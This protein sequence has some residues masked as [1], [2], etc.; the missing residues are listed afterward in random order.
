MPRGLLEKEHM[1]S[2][3]RSLIFVFASAGL[4][5]V[6]LAGPNSIPDYSKESKEVAP[7]PP[8]P[9]CDWTG[10]YIGL[11][12]GGQFGDSHDVDINGYNLRGEHWGYDESGFVGGGQAGYNW[13]WKWLVLGPEFD[14]GY[15]N[16]DGSH[17][18][19][20]SIPQS[21]GDTSGKSDSDLYVT[22][23]GRV[24]VNVDWHGC[25][26]LYATGGGIGVNYETRVVDT[27]IIP[28]AGDGLIDAHKEEFVW[29][30]TVG[31]GIERQ[32]GRHWSVKIEYLYFNLED[33]SFTG[34]ATF[35]GFAN[36]NSTSGRPPRLDHFKGD[37]DGNIVRA[38]LNFRF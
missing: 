12:A 16:L 5:A 11:H 3:A 22:L 35:F 15:M 4:A 25:W 38:G 24:G 10:F 7:V 6:A 26:L 37:T 17:V 19:P 18:Q 14:V 8:P 27:R 31:G 1:K 2:L 30:Y 29:G 33:Q 32:I 28:P 23:R 20:G 36:T 13:Q 21:D 9:G 34:T